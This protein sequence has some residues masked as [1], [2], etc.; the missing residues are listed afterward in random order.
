M[1]LHWTINKDGHLGM[2][3]GVGVSALFG[4]NMELYELL[5]LRQLMNLYDLVV[6]TMVARGE[7]QVRVPSRKTFLD[8]LRKR[9][10]IVLFEPE[11]LVPRIKFLEGEEIV[12]L[13]KEECLLADEDTGSRMR[14]ARHEVVA[15][16][17]KLPPGKQPSMEAMVRAREM[18][19]TL[20]V[21]ETFARKHERGEGGSNLSKPH[22]AHTRR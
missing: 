18:G 17:R 20:G 10:P 4:G 22:R 12:E 7:S 1:V 3:P 15:H 2:N 6:P 14:I 11:L 13:L 8:V 19:I 21:G 9:S 16:V 5:R